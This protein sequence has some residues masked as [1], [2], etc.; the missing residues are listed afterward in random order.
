MDIGTALRQQRERTG[1]SQTKL[2]KAT[3]IK[4]QTLSRWEDN[5]NTPNIKHCI[6]LAQY[7]G[8]TLEELLD[9]DLP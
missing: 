1:I 2:A 7:Y 8:I 5:T 6:L 9:I 3:G 4:Q